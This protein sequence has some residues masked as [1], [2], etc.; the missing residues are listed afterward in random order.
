MIEF[1]VLTLFPDMFSSFKETSIC[2][3]AIDSGR[4]NIELI[5]FRNYTEDKHRRVDDYPFGGGAGMLIGPQSVFDCFSDIS[6]K[7]EGKKTR[8][9]FM[10]PSGKVLSHADILRLSEYETINILCGH[11]E[12]VDQRIIDNLI[13][14]E[15]SI[16]DYVLTGGELPAMV[17]MDAVM[18]YVPGVLG[19]I[20]SL[21]AESHS[22]S[23]LLEYPQY[24]RPEDFR[25]LKVPEI[26]LSGHHANIKKW[27]RQK[28][29]EKTAAVR[30][31]LIEKA[32]LDDEEKAMAEK[33]IKRSREKICTGST[34]K[35]KTAED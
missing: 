1:N 31:E 25:G 23:G 8:N 3:R 14:E 16:G 7:C 11:Y 2:K 34:N 33:I 13:D 32:G 27:Q 4:I 6:K 18:R 15:I 17:L 10:S 21:E 24:T 35:Q 29:I 28:A 9:I 20:E 19:N 5:D 30:P 26:L 22:G 12:G